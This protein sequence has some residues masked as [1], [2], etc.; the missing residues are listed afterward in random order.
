MSPPDAPAPSP[1]KAPAPPGATVPAAPA[2][3]PPPVVPAPKPPAPAPKPPAPAPPPFPAALAGLDVEVIPGAGAVVAL[4][5]DA[6]ANSAGL[7]SILKTL[8][9]LHVD[10][11]DA[12]TLL[13]Q[14]QGG[15]ETDRTGTDD[16]DLRIGMTEHQASLIPVRFRA[17]RRAPARPP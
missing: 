16:E 13:L 8:A 17:G 10:D 4:T 3:A 7:P 5:F 1:S 9:A 2:P 14:E 6:G 12:D 15:N 11:C